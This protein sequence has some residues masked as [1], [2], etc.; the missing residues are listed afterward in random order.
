[1]MSFVAT[2]RDDAARRT[3]AALETQAGEDN[4]S[5]RIIRDV[6]LPVARAIRAFGEE[7][8]ES[9]FD[10]LLDVRKRA[11]A[12]GG[13]NAQRDVLNLTLIEAAI[14][15]GNTGA[16][17]ALVNERRAE[18]EESPF[19]ECLFKRIRGGKKPANGVDR[20]A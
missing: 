14:R 9:C 2:G 3:I 8:Y 4:S 15:A 17:T 7:D 5:S 20:A 1:M 18:K 10:T 11:A 19:A 13:S 12:F 6:G 16:A